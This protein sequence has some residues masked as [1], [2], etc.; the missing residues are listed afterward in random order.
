[1]WPALGLS[2]AIAASGILRYSVC[3]RGAQFFGDSVDRGQGSRRSI[4][5]TFDDGPGPGSLALLEYLKRESVKATF[6]VCGMNAL[7]HP[8]IVRRLHDAGHEIGNHTFSHRRLCPRVGWQM[9]VISP[10]EIYRELA[11]TQRIL[12]AETG[13]APCWFRAPYGMRWWGLGR[14][15]KKL[16]LTGVMWTVIGHDWEW[17]GDR[18]AKYVLG[19]VSAG[20]IVCLHDGR[21]T[22]PDPDIS[23]TLRAVMKIVP[24]LK[25][26]GYSFETVSEIRS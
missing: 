9:N 10:D 13:V 23:E 24:A 22:R 4:A 7:R 21:D 5:L 3:G 18:V 11:Y 12:E 14:A 6:F 15:Q 26:L 1:M 25:E 17:N 16:G 8:G 19:K 2:T 20:G